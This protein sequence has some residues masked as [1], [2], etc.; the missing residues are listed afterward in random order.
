MQYNPN[1]LNGF[2]IVFAPMKICQ[3]SI[4]MSTKYVMI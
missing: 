1:N 2:S 3:N 4:K